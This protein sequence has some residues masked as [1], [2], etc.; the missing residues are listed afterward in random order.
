VIRRIENAGAGLAIQ[1]E[2]GIN[3]NYERFL[4]EAERT[5][6]RSAYSCLCNNIKITTSTWEFIEHKP[7]YAYLEHIHITH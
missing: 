6:G 4:I 2:D 7:D 1:L 3:K 5:T